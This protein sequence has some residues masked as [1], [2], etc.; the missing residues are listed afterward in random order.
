VGYRTSIIESFY[1]I[2]KKSANLNIVN[3]ENLGKNVMK[4]GEGNKRRYY[5]GK[6]LKT[7]LEK[8]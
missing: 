4:I 8:M 6:V 2:S 5:F 3:K 7:S 1:A